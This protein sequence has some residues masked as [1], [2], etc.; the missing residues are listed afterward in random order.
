MD[1][2]SALLFALDRVRVAVLGLSIIVLVK[3]AFLLLGFN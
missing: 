2:L 3:A 1:A